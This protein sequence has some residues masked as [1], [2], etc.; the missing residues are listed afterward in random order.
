ME[1]YIPTRLIE[2]D[3]LADIPAIITRAL[4]THRSAGRIDADVLVSMGEIRSTRDGQHWRLTFDLGVNREPRDGEGRRRVTAYG[5]PVRGGFT[6]SGTFDEYGWILS[7]LYAEFEWMIVGRP[8][9]PVY[10][11]RADFTHKT[12]LTYDPVTLLS[13]IERTMNDP[14]PYITMRSLN[15]SRGKGRSD[16]E[17]IPRYMLTAA[18]ESYANDTRNPYRSVTF[19]P[20][21]VSEIRA[22]A[23]IDEGVSA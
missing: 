11:D 10:R 12:G 2:F 21:D 7:E 14:Y 18:I 17:G 20:R 22:F 4:D 3:E 15:G 23:R 13:L 5:Y 9:S 8:A 16:G 19:A 6:A 1:I